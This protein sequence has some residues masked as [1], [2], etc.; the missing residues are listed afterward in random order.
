MSEDCF[1]IV[2]AK[3]Y[4]PLGITVH[5]YAVPEGPGEGGLKDVINQS[6]P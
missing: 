1:E 3:M 5:I 4:M 6:I 2:T